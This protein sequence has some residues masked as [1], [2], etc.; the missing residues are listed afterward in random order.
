MILAEF[1]ELSTR[2]MVTRDTPCQA[3][4]TFSDEVVQKNFELLTLERYQ[5]SVVSSNRYLLR[6]YLFN[7]A[8]SNRYL[9]QYLQKMKKM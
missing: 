9:L 4:G 2:E 8:S 7:V 5:S 6:R 1:N 3:M